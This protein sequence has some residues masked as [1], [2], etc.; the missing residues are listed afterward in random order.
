MH[1]LLIDKF[2][3]TFRIIYRYISVLVLNPIFSFLRQ[4]NRT[5]M[6]ANSETRDTLFLISP[7]FTDENY[8]QSAEVGSQPTYYCPYCMAV[9]G[10]IA[11]FPEQL[12]QLK[13]ERVPYAL[14]RDSVAAILGTNNQSLPVLLLGDDIS[15]EIV[16][17][18][19]GKARF[20]AGHISVL[21]ALS[22]R[23]GIPIPHF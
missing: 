4:S 11:C 6:M 21:R 18:K 9:E 5:K 2:M 15:Q 3:P 23:Y 8:M 19:F 14:P 7:G 12:A 16:A 1:T 13:V 22:Q 20:V 17:E 10:V